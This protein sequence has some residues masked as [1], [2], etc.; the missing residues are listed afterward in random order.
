MTAACGGGSQPA[1]GTADGW[2]SSPVRFVFAS[3][4]APAHIDPALA[5]DLDSFSAT[6][7]L[8]DPL[9]WEDSSLKTIPWLATE[10]STSGDGLTTTLKLRSGVQFTD[11][12][13]FSSADVKLTIE[14]ILA[15]KQGPFGLLSAVKGVQAPDPQTVAITTA[16]PDPYL[17]THLTRVGI[18]SSAGV[19][20]HK[21]GDDPWATK[22]FDAN[23]DGTGPYTLGSWQ[24]GVQMTLNK[25]KGWWHG[26]EPG[27]VDVAI[28][29]FV[30]ETSARVQMVERGTADFTELWPTADALRVGA[31]KGFKVEKV[32]TF[33]I[34]PM[35][36]LNTKKPP[37]DNKLVR[38][39]AQ[40]AFDYDAMLSY[41]KG[42]ATAP[43]GPIPN[44][45]PGVA[46]FPPYKRDLEKAK[47]LIQQSGVDLAQHPVRFML[48][49][50]I[51][52]FSVGA[53]IFQQSLQQAG[54][55]VQIQQM[56]FPQ[57]LAA[58]SKVETAGESSAIIT[59]PYT[60][61]PTVF[62]GNFYLP[63]GVYN[64]SLYDSPQVNQ[65]IA[66]ARTSQDEKA[67]TAALQQAQTIVRDDAPAIWAARPK[68]VVALPE[69][70]TGFTMPLTDYRWS[71]YFWPLK[72]KA[73]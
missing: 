31:K 39:A 9:V 62:L 47:A 45:Y 38:Q 33:E 60:A 71:M 68:T 72:I 63:G 20:A 24:K 51:D 3:A 40:L 18:V 2:A 5:V 42:E 49:A 41:Y 54:F 61:D 15:L 59:S 35:F 17:L 65:L 1:K 53:T 44:D 8:Y 22:W 43:T 21:T 70:V 11:G 10:W 27:S 4:M 56:P 34:D 32:S 46:Q 50:G 67:R 73:H 58:F 28:N 30:T 6:R 12:S 36:Y 19:A 16:N 66:T 52:S 69:Y 25:N 13:A 26:W 23:S 37:F 7:N 14:R 55:K 64:F 29:K 57:V 48:P